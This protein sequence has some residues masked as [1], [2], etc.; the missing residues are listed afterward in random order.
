MRCNGMPVS[1]AILSATA[2]SGAIGQAGRR[3]ARSGFGGARSGS[4]RVTHASSSASFAAACDGACSSR[5]VS[6]AI[7]SGV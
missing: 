4:P 1:C 2:S 7:R 3:R 5:H 6:A